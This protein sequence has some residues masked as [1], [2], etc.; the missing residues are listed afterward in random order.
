MA[1]TSVSQ[2][3]VWDDSELLTSWNEAL[4]E[5]KVRV[6]SVTIVLSYLTSVQK[7]HSLAAKGE[8]VNLAAER[9]LPTATNGDTKDEADSQEQQ[10]TT[11]PGPSTSDET[12]LD[13]PP[14]DHVPTV[15]PQPV[16]A[17][18]GGATVAIPQ[19]LMATGKLWTDVFILA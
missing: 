1:D 12:K 6:H 7:Y 8:K 11:L 3:E 2:S 19:A 14:S 15:P 13:G 10:P 5:Y 17:P 18:G 9:L 16:P 4:E